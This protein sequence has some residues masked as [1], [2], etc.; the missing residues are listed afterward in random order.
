MARLSD[1]CELTT[2]IVVERSVQQCWDLY[3]DNAQ[4]AQWAPAV[5]SVE[6]DN[7]LLSINS[8]RKNCVQVDG[9]PGHT[10]EQCTVFDPLK[11]IEFSV[12][13]ETF[14][15]SH[16]LNSYGHAL[17]FDVEGDH[18]LMVMKTHYVPKKIFAS[19]MTAKTTP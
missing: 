11:S 19:L 13:E 3:I 10:V 9:K 15:F 5:S 4:M 6:C 14:G 18:T 8:V 17:S 2:S 7:P 12:L 16:M 1:P